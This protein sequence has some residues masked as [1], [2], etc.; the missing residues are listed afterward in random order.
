MSHLW[1]LTIEQEKEVYLPDLLACKQA[2]IVWRFRNHPT[3]GL[4]EGPPLR[5]QH[6]RR[7]VY[8]WPLSNGY[9]PMDRLKHEHPGFRAWAR[10]PEIDN[11]FTAIELDT[12]LRWAF[13]VT[14]GP[15]A[16]T[17]RVSANRDFSLE[18]RVRWTLET[19]QAWANEAAGY[20]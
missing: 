2:D 20:A 3:I 9:D 8:F 16:R 7:V 12:G 5:Q 1:S 6:G 14:G 13:L 4:A 11:G 17:M 19:L 10:V 15:S 18:T